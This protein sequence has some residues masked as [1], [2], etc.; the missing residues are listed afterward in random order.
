M[1]PAVGSAPPLTSL[2]EPVP[3]WT[4]MRPPLAG[5]LMVQ[6]RLPPTGTVWPL[7]Q[8][9]V[10][11]EPGRLPAFGNVQRAPF[12]VAVPTLVQVTVQ[13]R[14]WPVPAG[15]GVHCV[16]LTMS[17]PEAGGLIGTLVLEGLL[18]A[19]GSVP[20]LASLVAV[21]EAFTRTGVAKVGVKVSV[22]A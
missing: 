6:A 8:A 3:P 15:L 10:D 19:T 4:G 14:L 22:Q 13:E 18:P 12:A 7:G 21:A 1:L 9:A 5:K 11:G 2:V 17:A 20:P 16:R